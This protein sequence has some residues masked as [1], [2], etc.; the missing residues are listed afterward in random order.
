MVLA[1]RMAAQCLLEEKAHGEQHG[2]SPPSRTSKTIAA[3][4]HWNRQSNQGANVLLAIAT[5]MSKIKICDGLAHL[6]RHSAVPEASFWFC[7]NEETVHAAHQG[8][9]KGPSGLQI[10]RCACCGKQ[11]D[12]GYRQ[13]S[14][15]RQVQ[16]CIG[17]YGKECQVQ[18]GKLGHKLDCANVAKLKDAVKNVDCFVSEP[19]CDLSLSS[20]H[21]LE[22]VG[23]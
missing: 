11:I 19:K 16:G 14:V 23:Y 13:N 12:G 8:P 9:T 18:H 7:L 2:I 4:L 17:Y 5:I 3:E 10:Y 1:L 6:P 15:A 20:L 21:C 22:T